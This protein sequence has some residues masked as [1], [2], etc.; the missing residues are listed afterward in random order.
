MHKAAVV[1]WSSLVVSSCPAICASLLLLVVVVVVVVVL[2]FP[3]RPM[4]LLRL[5]SAAVLF[6]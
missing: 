6:P 5:I 3:L 4:L 1:P 2:L